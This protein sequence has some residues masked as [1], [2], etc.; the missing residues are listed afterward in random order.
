LLVFIPNLHNVEPP[1]FKLRLLCPIDICIDVYLLLLKLD[2]AIV[3]CKSMP[4]KELSPGRGL[5][6][7]AQ[8]CI[9]CKAGDNEEHLVIIWLQTEAT[10]EVAAVVIARNKRKPEGLGIGDEFQV[11]SDV[12][13]NE[14]TTGRH[15]KEKRTKRAH[16]F[17]RVLGRP[18][19]F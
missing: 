8:F 15:L 11:V 12:V 19:Q 7:E 14:L 3:N 16:R 17:A 10:G 4:A 18:R 1:L 13:Q 6:C 2:S 5:D 9:Q